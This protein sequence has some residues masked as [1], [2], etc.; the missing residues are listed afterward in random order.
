LLIAGLADI[1]QASPARV[2]FGAVWGIITTTIILA[3]S[4]KVDQRSVKECWWIIFLLEVAFISL[5]LTIRSQAD[6]KE[7]VNLAMGV[8][9]AAAAACAGTY[10]LAFLGAVVGGW[11]RQVRLSR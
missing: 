2:A 3:F 4:S 10:L 8:M 9:P 7:V 11:A 6:N 5:L 1:S